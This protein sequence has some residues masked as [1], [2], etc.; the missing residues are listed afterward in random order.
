MPYRE[1]GGAEDW[2]PHNFLFISV[3]KICHFL[4][5]SIENNQKLRRS[6][7][8]QFSVHLNTDTEQAHKNFI[9]HIL[10]LTKFSLLSLIFFLPHFSGH[11][12]CTHL[13]NHT[14]N[15]TG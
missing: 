9:I 10:N 3:T 12:I 5:C 1:G 11:R 4:P 7:S 13:V 14:T 6:I 8:P 2:A 15:F